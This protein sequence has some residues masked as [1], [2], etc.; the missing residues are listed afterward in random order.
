MSEIA[1][2]DARRAQSAPMSGGGGGDVEAAVKRLAALSEF[3]YDRA[4][5]AEA[6]KLGVRVTTLDSAVERA[7]G[8]ASCDGARQGAVLKLKQPEPWLRPS[9]AKR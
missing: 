1:L 2:K 9:T 6:E 7:R 5:A 4:R 8:P 3:D